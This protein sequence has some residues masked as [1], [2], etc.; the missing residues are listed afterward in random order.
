[1]LLLRHQNWPGLRP[2]PFAHL[3]E[4]Y[5]CLGRTQDLAAC[6]CAW[7]VAT[8]GFVFSAAGSFP[9]GHWLVMVGCRVA[10]APRRSCLAPC[11][12]GW[13]VR[14]AVEQ[15][16]GEACARQASTSLGEQ[17]ERRAGAAFG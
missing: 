13:P 9:G 7:Q 3:A 1:M 15:Q 10:A 6:T 11:T 14:R 4:G 12:L 16:G 17:L 8:R 2:V 5:A